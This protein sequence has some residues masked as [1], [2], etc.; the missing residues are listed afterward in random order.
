MMFILYIVYVFELVCVLRKE[1]GSE[2][3]NK[4]ILLLFYNNIYFVCLKKQRSKQHIKKV[5]QCIFLLKLY[6][7]INIFNPNHRVVTA[8]GGQGM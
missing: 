6:F 7:I 8:L 5:Y 4:F 1:W 3:S 2:T